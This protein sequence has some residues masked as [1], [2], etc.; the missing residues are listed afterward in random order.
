LIIL[1]IL[2]VDDEPSIG[3][4][5]AMWCRQDGHTASATTSSLKALELISAAVPDLL[6]TDA[7]LPEMDGLLLVR[8]AQARFPGIMAIVIT[9]HRDYSLESVVAAGA[10][11][12]ILK[13]LRAPELRAR[14]RLAERTREQQAHM[15]QKQKALQQRTTEIIQ[16]LKRELAEERSLRRVRDGLPIRARPRK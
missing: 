15:S 1:R 4:L 10:S 6:I 13:P 9:G 3:E 12:L 11:D 14:I 16:G 5:V 7:R 2:V 8:H